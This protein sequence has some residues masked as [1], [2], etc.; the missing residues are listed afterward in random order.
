[1]GSIIKVNLYVCRGLEGIFRIDNDVI[2]VA[3]DAK[4]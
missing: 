1:L 2:E 4:E 3:F